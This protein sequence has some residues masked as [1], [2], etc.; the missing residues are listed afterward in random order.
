MRTLE[1]IVVSIY[2]VLLCS[3]AIKENNFLLMT[4][5]LIFNVESHLQLFYRHDTWVIKIFT[6]FFVSKNTHTDRYTDRQSLWMH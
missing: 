2:A 4:L 1:N 5:K 3:E 6:Q